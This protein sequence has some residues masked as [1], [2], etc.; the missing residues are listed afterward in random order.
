MTS[1]DLKQLGKPVAY[2]QTYA[3]HLLEKFKNQHPQKNLFITLNCPEFTSLCPITGQPDFAQIYINYLPGDWCIESK[4]LKLYLFSYRNHGEFHE[5]CICTIMNDLTG[6]I[7][8]RYLEVKGKFLPRGGISID[9]FVYYAD[10]KHQEFAQQRQ[11]A[12]N[13]P[14]NLINNRG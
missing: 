14:Q 9:P 13:M 1:H 8:P 11:L 3:P 4:S 12:F 2:P 5:N 7:Q 6:L 10:E